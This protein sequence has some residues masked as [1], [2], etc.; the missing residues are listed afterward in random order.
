MLKYKIFSLGGDTRVIFA[1]EISSFLENCMCHLDAYDYDYYMCSFQ[2]K[3]EHKTIINDMITICNYT[4]E[5]IIIIVG[6]KASLTLIVK[7]NQISNIK[8]PIVYNQTKQTKTIHLIC[9]YKYCIFEIFIFTKY[10]YRKHQ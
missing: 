2:T 8:F 6:D 1:E 3:T 9:K 7:S 5:I 10:A 4:M